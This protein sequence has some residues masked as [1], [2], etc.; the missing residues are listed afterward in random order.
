MN[1][2]D[3]IVKNIGRIYL[4]LPYLK[5][6][7]I[8]EKINSMVQDQGNVDIGRVA[9]ILILNRACG[10][11][12]P[13]YQLSEWAEKH[14]I[15][16]VY[17]CLP[18]KLNDD[19]VGEV[20][21]KLHSKLSDLDSLI[22]LGMIENYDID[23][24]QVH[25]DASSF[26]VTGNQISHSDD[27]KTIDVTYGRSSNDITYRRQVR[28][29]ITISNDGA[30]PLT[31]SA[32]SGNA[33]D[34]E[35]HPEALENLRSIGKTSN[36]LFVADSKF[37]SIKNLKN[38]FEHKG[39]FLC[40]GSFSVKLKKEFLSLQRQNKILWENIS[41][42]SKTDKKK[43]KS[44]REYYKSFET[45]KTLKTKENRSL[46]EYPYRFIYIYSSSN[47]KQDKKTREKYFNRIY[48]ELEKIIPRL[49]RDKYRDKKYIKEKI[50]SILN[51]KKV[52]GDY[53]QPNFD[54]AMVSSR[55]SFHITK[56][57]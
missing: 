13:L 19:R 37:D 15:G 43:P 42:I 51:M 34:Y 45:I 3:I 21:D 12:T 4:F 54:A 31:G 29:G 2:Q 6:L 22:T 16:E 49:N 10:F 50:N 14:C 41:Y 5:T 46:T 35:M 7:K 48:N 17:G 25:F 18:S 9:E 20:L 36:F 23:I 26:K 57:K 11:A 8:G 33:S 56:T 53:F 28:C 40:P 44:K 52:L 47:A 24:S 32:Y 38:V 30:I 55:L 27:P 1:I 39:K